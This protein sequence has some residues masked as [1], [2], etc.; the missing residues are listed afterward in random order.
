MNE[1]DSP[2]F[3]RHL[4]N[5]RWITPT[6][7]IMRLKKD[8]IEI[9]FN[10]ERFALLDRDSNEKLVNFHCCLVLLFANAIW[11]LFNLLRISLRPRY[12]TNFVDCFINIALNSWLQKKTHNQ[13]SLKF[14]F[15][16]I[17][18]SKKSES[19]LFIRTSKNCGI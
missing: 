1:E 3:L 2:H 17:S 6:T 13:S 12:F 15:Y 18:R 19:H 11:F 5:D 10:L 9:P 4:R 14:F 16:K 8:S 7:Y